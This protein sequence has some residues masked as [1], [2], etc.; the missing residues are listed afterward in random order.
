MDWA[1]VSKLPT[2]PSGVDPEETGNS[3][4]RLVFDGL[5]RQ[6]EDI[7]QLL[8]GVISSARHRVTI[9]TPYFI[10]PR[11]LAGA[12][13]A[14]V[15][16]G[17]RVDIILPAKNNL[18]YVHHASRRYQRQL[19][20]MGVRIWYQPPPFAHTK[21]LLVDDWYALFGSANLDP[22]SLFL[23]FELNVEAAD[24]DF[25]KELSSYADE[26]LSRSRLMPPQEYERM[27][28]AACLFDSVCWLMSPY[29]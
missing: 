17:V 10:P 15:Q 21:L 2:P 11:E 23:N 1:F 14:A 18:F 5:G 12:L 16:R 20:S 6:R 3:H 25:Q 24:P 4:C 22:R 29:I 26:I 9:F 27:S 7:H 8:C 28:L 13:V 19:A